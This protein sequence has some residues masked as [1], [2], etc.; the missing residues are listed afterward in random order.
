[1]TPPT[2]YPALHCLK[3]V[4]ANGCFLPGAIGCIATVAGRFS[5]LQSL[6]V[7]NGL[8]RRTSAWW[9]RK[10][11]RAWAASSVLLYEKLSGNH[12]RTSL[13]CLLT[14]LLLPGCI[15]IPVPT[16]EKP[17]FAVAIPILQVGVTSKSEVLEELGVPDVTYRGGSELVYI[18]KQESWNIVWGFILLGPAGGAAGGGLETLHTRFV[19]SLS[20][21]TRDILS[22]FE[23]DKA[24]DDFGDCSS[25]G[26][27]FGKTNNAVMRYADSATEAMAKGFNV[28]EDQCSIYLYGPGTKKAYE[29]SLNGKT[30]VNMFSTRAFV[31][32]MVK[33]GRQSLVTYPEA[34]HLDFGCSAGEIVF[35]RFQHKRLSRS[36]L[37]L[38]DSPTGRAHIANRHLVL[39]PTG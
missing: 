1:M 39:L 21:D 13:L 9:T 33:P 4:P 18:E 22:E 17:Y 7:L 37:Y 20:F 30:P 14:L 11:H 8:F 27:C 5:N 35:V 34:A 6:Q 26:I 36:N 28:S 23:F 25:H 10:S 12:I 19:L 15:V 31:H 2:A 32:W 29:V 24:G 3:D 38:E 16:G